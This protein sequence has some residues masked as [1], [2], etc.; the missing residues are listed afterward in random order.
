[1]TSYEREK[2]LYRYSEL[3]ER[4][5]FEHIADILRVAED[6]PELERAIL[7]INAAYDAE[8]AQAQ[9]SPALNHNNHP[10]NNHTRQI[11][12]IDMN[13]SIARS[14]TPAYPLEFPR[15]RSFL[16]ISAAAAVVLIFAA[17]IFAQDINQAPN[18]NYLGVTAQPEQTTEE[19]NL[20]LFTRYMDEAW[21]GGNTDILE[22]LLT[23]NHLFIPGDE[24]E[25]E[26]GIEPVVE[27]ISMFHE[28]M[29][30]LEFSVGETIVDDE[31]VFAIVTMQATP[32]AT[33]LFESDD[34]TFPMPTRGEPISVTG[35]VIVWIRDDQIKKTWWDFDFLELMDQVFE[36]NILDDIWYAP[37]ITELA[38]R[39]TDDVWAGGN[40]DM[41]DALLADRVQ[42]HLPDLDKTHDFTSGEVKQW[43]GEFVNSFEN[44]S[45]EVLDFA[46]TGQTA[47]VHVQ[48]Q[49]IFVNPM[50]VTVEGEE[51]E[52]Q[53]TNE[54]LTM[55]GI[56]I[57]RF[58]DN[59]KLSEMWAY[60]LGLY[61]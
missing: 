42:V 8:T 9:R 35:T 29:N 5:D 49:G 1:M 46:T 38:T 45:I 33:I 7:E 44:F 15:R 40:V 53:P 30:D 61:P 37:I 48:V 47:M 31:R 43:I 14:P 27:Q 36:I 60:N 22:E 54:L 41:A 52:V 16:T 58:D 57:Y 25:A 13:I 55:D 11:E 28:F 39:L 19:R 50:T 4:G 10:I 20:A 51:V 2:L 3:L 23:P 26:L 24:S 32:D 56:L 59:G 17:I 34:F 18:N 21:T 12:D 6:D